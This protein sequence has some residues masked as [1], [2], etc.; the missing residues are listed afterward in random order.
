M[1]ICVVAD[2]CF[3]VP[4]LAGA[5]ADY[6]H[7]GVLQHSVSRL[8]NSLYTCRAMFIKMGYFFKCAFRTICRLKRIVTNLMSVFFPLFCWY[9]WCVCARAYVCLL[10]I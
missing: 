10:L 1:V 5:A 7:C 4:L 6:W 9:F 2:V 8:F 3:V